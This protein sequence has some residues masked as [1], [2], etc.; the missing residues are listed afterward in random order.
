MKEK[1]DQVTNTK[2]T[3]ASFDK[4]DIEKNKN[5]SIL[6]YLSW[7]VIIPLLTAKESPF[8]RYHC[9][10]G[11]VLA[12]AEIAAS[13]VLGLLGMIPKVGWI[14]GIL[15]GLL[16]ILCVVLAILGIVNAANGKAKELPLVGGV[17]ILK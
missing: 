10:Q 9:N 6:A 15:N 12:I 4:G 14:F 17:R 8:A 5:I 16:W 1:F 3:T 2:D 7:L 13:V 11:L